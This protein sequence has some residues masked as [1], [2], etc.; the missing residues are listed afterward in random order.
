MKDLPIERVAIISE[1]SSYVRER[2]D[3]S[4]SEIVYSI[5]RPQGEY[6]NKISAVLNL[7]DDRIL[8]RIETAKKLETNE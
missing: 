2:P 7:N 3:M 6:E 4:I 5:F 8:E 1:L